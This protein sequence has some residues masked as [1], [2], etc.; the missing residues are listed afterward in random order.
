M[1]KIFQYQSG[2]VIYFKGDPADRV[3]ILQSGVVSLT[4]QDMESG[5][6]LRDTVQQGE[7]FGVKSAM[8]RYAREENAV[9]LKDSAVMVFSVPEFENFAMNNT[10]I[11]MKMLTVFS[12]QLRGVH[13]QL[14]VLLKT[15]EQNP[16]AGLFSI[17]EYYFK[18]KR[19]EHAKYVF[20]RYLACY[21]S[22]KDIAMAKANLKLAEQ[23]AGQ[24]AEATAP[25][26]QNDASSAYQRALDLASQGKYQQA[27]TIFKQITDSEPQSEWA[28]KSA[29]E[30]GRCFYTLKKFEECI[31]YFTDMLSR[32]PQHPNIEEAVFFI[33]QSNEQLGKKAQAQTLYRKILTMP[34]GGDGIK[35]K[36][37]QALE[38]LGA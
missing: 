37:K 30:I 5:N 35:T 24:S 19:F 15:R 20:S 16:E 33:G 26:E 17:G 38:G 13:R 32:Y 34:G 1:P 10:R 7:F 22:G 25:Q 21:P 11:V 27:Y 23:S 9:V 4:Y 12:T 18:Q 36:V 28:A 2:A 8:G 6:D 29:L 3:F 14:S 31:Q